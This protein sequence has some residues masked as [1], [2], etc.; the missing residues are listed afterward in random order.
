LRGNLR[1]FV[2]VFGIARR[3]PRLLHFVANHGDDGVVGDSALA[4]T[5]VIHDVTE[6]RLA[7]LHQAPKRTRF[8]LRKRRV[9]AAE[10]V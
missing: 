9:G 2:L 1:L 5:V 7:L 10:A 6:P 3:T 8:S 4:G